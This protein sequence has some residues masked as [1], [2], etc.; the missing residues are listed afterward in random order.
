M[1]RSRVG[2]CMRLLGLALFALV[3]GLDFPPTDCSAAATSAPQSACVACH[4]D[5][6]RLEALTPPDAPAEEQGEG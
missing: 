4:T 1:A 6:A 3:A 2:R 5:G